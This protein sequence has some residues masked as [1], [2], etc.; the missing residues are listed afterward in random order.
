[1]ALGLV[2]ALMLASGLAAGQSSAADATPPPAATMWTEIRW[3]FRIDEWGTGRAFA[4][5]AVDCGS[6]MALYLRVKAG[7]CNCATGVA[8]DDDLDRVADLALFSDS[9]VGLA[10]GRPVAVDD[11]AGRSRPY[12][13][14]LPLW[15]SQ[16]AVGMVL[17]AKCDALVA[18]VVADRDRLAAAE[19]N[20]LAFLNAAPVLRWARTEL[21]S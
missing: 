9:F 14:S 8:D 19:R 11:M 1:M 13:V 18:T 6:D 7:S 16:T 17:H 21:G 15:R 20:A 4:C 2:A 3:P 5:K 12:Q 10:A